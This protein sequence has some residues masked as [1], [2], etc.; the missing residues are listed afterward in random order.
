MAE[1]VYAAADISNIRLSKIMS[2]RSEVHAKLSLQEFTSLFRI[3]WAFVISCEVI[4]R[5]MIVGLRGEM[6]SQAKGFLLGF[7]NR[8]IAE[9]SKQV[10]EERWEP[11]DVEEETQ[12][13][14]EQI[15][16][17]AVK[18]PK[19]FM[20][21]DPT[22]PST[23][24]ANAESK[25]PN[26]SWKDAIRPNGTFKLPF[27]SK[28][29]NGDAA[30]ALAKPKRAKTL[31]DVEDRSFFGVKA[32]LKCVEALAEYLKVVFNL[33]LLTIDAIAK[34][35]EFLKAF[36]SRTCQVVLGAGAMRSAGLKNITARHLALASQSL[37]IMTSLIP[38]AREALRRHLNAKQAVML[39][40]FDRL[41]RDYQDHQNEIHSKLVAIMQ[42]R[43]T[44]H[45]ASLRAIDWDTNPEPK[46]GK[47]NP[48]METLVKEVSTLHK[49]FNSI[50]E[51]IKTEMIKVDIKNESIRGKM[52]KDVQ[53]LRSKL[54]ELKGMEIPAPGED[55]ENTISV[56]SVATPEPPTPTR[57]STLASLGSYGYAI[58]LP[59]TRFKEGAKDAPLSPRIWSS[60]TTS[61]GSTPSTPIASTP[62]TSARPS[63][64][65]SSTPPAPS[66]LANEINPMS[67][68][69]ST[70]SL[71]LPTNPEFTTIPPSPSPPNSQEETDGQQNPPPL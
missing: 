5:R 38:Y 37:S 25:E 26:G 23:A 48:Y 52:L 7:H 68:P 17:S 2:V 31:I 59:S 27:S 57:R 6:V 20:L 49:V 33:E 55:I 42:D 56:K 45:C 43:L 3:S 71:P 65:I 19:E 39:V 1:I 21:D 54:S 24:T 70:E 51:G 69:L 61:S 4:S 53:Y 29:T 12:E 66:S 62:P 9:M 64:D 13:V 36:N 44:V 11:A 22:K 67:P 10:E 14:V 60:V 58:R 63:M 40:E 35:V 46:E 8:M 32:S 30:A 34:I 28:A 18:D 50:N 16:G 47:A 15:L 41:K